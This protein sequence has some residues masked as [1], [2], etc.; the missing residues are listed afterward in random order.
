MTIYRPENGHLPKAFIRKNDRKY[1]HL[2]SGKMVI[3][4]RHLSG[5]MTGN[6]TIYR[7]EKWSFTKSIYPENDRK[8]D[9]LPKAL[10]PEK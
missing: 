6:M 3:Y 9:H 10:F 5:K 4:Q 7:P 8:Y 2:P 1:D